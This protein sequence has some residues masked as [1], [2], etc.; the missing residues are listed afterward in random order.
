MDDRAW[1]AGVVPEQAHEGQT[2][3]YGDGVALRGLHGPDVG[4][5]P[6]AGRHVCTI[7]AL[8]PAAPLLVP[9]PAARLLQRRRL[10]RL[11]QLQVPLSRTISSFFKNSSRTALD[12]LKRS[13]T[14]PPFSFPFNQQL[15]RLMIAEEN[16]IH[17]K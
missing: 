10:R 4:S 16:F 3:A 14:H 5:Q 6:A 1:V 8:L 9:I 12:R 7:P 11:A 15:T 2:A 13:N 17:T